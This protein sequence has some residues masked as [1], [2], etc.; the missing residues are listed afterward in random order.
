MAHLFRLI[1]G[2]VLLLVL[3]APAQALV[4]TVTGYATQASISL[5]YFPTP[6]AACNAW[7]V[8]LDGGYNG[9]TTNYAPWQITNTS[10][11]CQMK[12][13]PFPNTTQNQVYI[14]GQS[15]PANSTG[16]AGGCTCAAGYQENAAKTACE[17]LPNECEALT[18]KSA[19]SKN[20]EGRGSEF[21]FCDGW[22]SIGGGKC[23]AKVGGDLIRWESP[24][25]S[26]HW[27]SQGAATYT[28][29]TGSSC[30][31][32]GLGGDSPSQD[33][34]PPGAPAPDTPKPGEAAPAP[35]PSG[36]Q[37]G[38]VNGTRVCAPTGTDVPK[39][40]KDSK[41]TTNP[42]GSKVKESSE[43]RCRDGKCTTD[44][45]KCTTPAG[46]T[47]QTCETTTTTQ[48][49]VALCSVNGAAGVCK[50]E[51]DGTPSRFSGSCAGGFKAVSD[52]A[53]VNAMAEETYRQNCKVNPDDAS[54]TLAKAEAVKTGNQTGDN[55]NNGSFN[56]GPSSFNTSDAIGA[57]SSC[58]ADKSVSI[59]GKSFLL[60]LSLVCDSLGALG[61]V[62]LAC[63][64][65]LA[66]RIVTR[67]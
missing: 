12:S 50:G 21:F 60:P 63:S 34:T 61:M 66:G 31:G 20:F 8:A 7:R 32:N 35:C 45:T 26:G 67:G 27:I 36:Q 46:S 5:G 56:V 44:T 16:G 6:E 3:G 38:E 42:D 47:L 55:P 11:R 62:L 15:C 37:P 22:N 49:Q 53:V 29:A 23:V 28:G 10:G 41:E 2:F 9:E 48:S 52:D 57:G 24:P 13:T 4:P 39:E 65:L 43:S 40:S 18:G 30:S 64:F 19:G 51:G 33:S 14:T 1:A 25:G 54:Q 17:L 58:I 59:A